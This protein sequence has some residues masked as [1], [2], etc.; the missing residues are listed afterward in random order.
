MQLDSY[1][2]IPS[3]NSYAAPS[4]STSFPAFS[5]FSDHHNNP[6]HNVYSKNIHIDSKKK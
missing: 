3:L 5:T 2:I 4:S 6:T 1:P